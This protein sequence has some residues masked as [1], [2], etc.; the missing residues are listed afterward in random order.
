MSSVSSGSD[1]S[2][3]LQLGPYDLREPVG[4]GGMGQV[5]LARHRP[6][7]TRVA[8]KLITGIAASN[9]ALLSAFR[10]EI[11][12]FA[13]LNHPSIVRILDRGE[14]P[15]SVEEATGGQLHAGTPFLVM[16]YVAGG[17]L[18]PWCGHLGWTEIR[19]VLLGL[20]DALA[21]AH[22]RG[23]IHRDIKPENVLLSADRREVKLTDFGLVHAVERAT[24][25]SRDRGLAGTPRYMAPEQCLGRWRDY[26]PWTDFY[27][28]GGLAY[29]LTTGR[30]P[31]A[32]IT[33]QYELVRAHRESPPPPL[34]PRA[35]VPEGFEAWLRVMLGKDPSDRYQRASEAAAALHALSEPQPRSLQSFSGD[36]DDEDTVVTDPAITSGPSIL[37]SRH[38]AASSLLLEDASLTDEYLIADAEARRTDGAMASVPQRW[39]P[40]GDVD[41]GALP[42]DALL[43]TGLG[44]YWLRSVP[45]VARHDERDE[46]WAALRRVQDL[47]RPEVAVLS[48]PAGV[49]KSRLARW[50]CERAHEIGGA[51]FVKASHSP[52]AGSPTGLG[53]MLARHFRTLGLRWNE[54]RSRLASVLAPLGVEDRGEA[55]AL[56]EVILPST[57]TS[58]S[59]ETRG[60]RFGSKDEVLILVARTL[61]RL[62]ARRPLVVWLDDVQWGPDSVRLVEHLL[63]G[64]KR[65]PVPV[66][67]IMTLDEGDL[68]EPSDRAQIEGL[69]EH[70]LA[71]SITLTPLPPQ[72]HQTLVRRLL[73]L[74]DELAIRV[75]ERTEGN[76]MF[77]MQLV[78]NWVDRD[79]LELGERGFRLREGSDDALPD[80]LHAVWAGRV[81]AFLRGPSRSV[82][83]GPAIELAATFG[84]G[85][86]EGDWWGACDLGGLMPSLGLM[87][88]LLDDGLARCGEE[89][90][91]QGWS[92]AHAML[93]ES[94]MRR[95]ADAGRLRGHHLAAAR[96]LGFEGGPG[97]S[98]AIARHLVSAGRSEEALGSL[99]S[100]AWELMQAGELRRAEAL[101]AELDRE[102]DSLGAK[103]KDPR[104]GQAMLLR[105]RLTAM[106]GDSSQFDKLSRQA[107]R[108][109]RRHRWRDIGVYLTYEIACQHVKEGALDEAASELAMVLEWAEDSGDQVLAAQC[110]QGQAEVA[111][112]RGEQAV[113]R[114]LY[115]RCIGRY[116]ELAEGLKAARALVALAELVARMGQAREVD[117][118]L[119]LGRD[120]FE[121]WGSRRGLA[122]VVRVQAVALRLSGDADAAVQAFG[123]AL[124]RYRSLGSPRAA[125]IEL[126]LAKLLVLL[127]RQAEAAPYLERSVPALE[128]SGDSTLLAAAHVARVAVAAAA[129]DWVAFDASVATARLLIAELAHVDRDLVALGEI[130]RL[131]AESA[132]EHERAHAAANI[133]LGL[134]DS[135]G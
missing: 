114:G 77:A 16:E 129:G 56:A 81:E 127:Q 55:D 113:A 42:P 69:L 45:F 123:D 22:A 54:V 68:D 29:A 25:G 59:E 94:L 110:L 135:G 99:L 28:L 53:S 34:K 105:L 37:V 12:A 133:T 30:P 70:A 13:G 39:S 119:E 71:W 4:A 125:E 15:R 20:L 35:P 33:A 65:D 126:E 51:D 87:E 104:R 96:L 78:G 82:H 62:A 32:N 79:V 63:G 67:V 8:V 83:D 11:R 98:E 72:D 41:D 43:G 7:S 75:E 131:A 73:H 50:L 85:L 3:R 106:A 1:P 27:A 107:E 76:P 88:D 14:L 84:P 101:L 74:D 86:T 26:G 52:G 57:N 40:P 90:P 120:L 17:S 48:G 38:P 49:G 91:S 61:S 18:A 97:R 116:E 128:T 112:L 19:G 103:K 92:F 124:R 132:G 109:A 2:A 6:T 21:H 10:N 47:K 95:A 36:E 118:Y 134:D 66:L 9:K 102:L 58:P 80:D 5:W 44:L 115:Q 89:G 121:R 93:R 31:F 23:L 130:A 24:P 108:L 46:L 60:V 64:A 117:V 100:G 122:D 111:V